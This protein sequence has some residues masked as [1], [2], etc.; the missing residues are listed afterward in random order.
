MSIVNFIPTVWSAR[1]QEHLDK[2]F[3]YGDIVNRDHEGEIKGAGDTVKINQIG[4]VTVSTYTPNSTSITYQKI[5]MADITLLIDQAKHFGFEVDDVD[6]AQALGGVMDG[7]MRRASYALGDVVDQFIAG[8]YTGASATNV[9]GSTGS[10]VAVNSSNV[11]AQFAALSQKLNEANVPTGGRW[12]VIPPWML[13]D[14]VISR[15]TTQTDNRD[16]LDNGRVMNMFGFDLRVSNN[17]PI[18]DSTKYKIIAGTTQ[19]ISFAGQLSVVEPYRREAS[20]SDAIRGLYVYGAKV[21]EPGALAI[22]TATE[23]AEA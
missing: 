2:T 19:A 18:V 6:R 16:I 4:P 9:V 23:A 21:V 11:I 15:A 13:A 12:A 17:V 8:L 20:F 1:L 5:D 3:V 10:P 7:A 22:L 14:L